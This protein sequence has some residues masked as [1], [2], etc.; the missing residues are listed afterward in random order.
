MS[1]ARKGTT[2]AS[3]LPLVGR[4]KGWGWTRPCAVGGDYPIPTARNAL[5]RVPETPSLTGKAN[6]FMGTATFHEAA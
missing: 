4:G 5:P 2:L 6:V 1:F 3:P